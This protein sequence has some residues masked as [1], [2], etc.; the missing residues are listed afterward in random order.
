MFMET[1]LPAPPGAP[2]RP[3]EGASKVTRQPSVRPPAVAGLFYPDDP[4]V[5]EATVRRLLDAAA[6]EGPPRPLALVAPHAGYAYS[7]PVAASAWALAA[8]GGPAVRRVA[9]LGPSHRVS[10]QG[11]ALPE[12]DTFATPLGDHAVDPDGVSALLAAPPVRRWA[13]AHRDEHS[14][15][16]QLPFVRL[17]LGDLP[18]LPLVTGDA[19]AEEVADALDR[20]WTHDTL[21]VVSSDLSHYLPYDRARAVDT[22]TAAAIEGLAPEGI[23][24]DRACGCV[25]L[26]GLLVA[27]KR[28]GLAARCVDLRSSGD[29]AGPRNRVVGYG[30]FGFWAAGA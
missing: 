5:L 29:T 21:V 6:P 2:V 18:V 13:R 10:F 19:S 3:H 17:A 30:A 12:D 28:R 25:A 23:G 24:P 27:A 20:V 8:T 7:G 4:R 9:L 11:M 16:V 14:L 1:T 26:R 22:E 15:E